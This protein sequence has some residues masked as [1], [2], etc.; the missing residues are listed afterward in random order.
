V[1]T[2]IK[3]ITVKHTGR[4]ETGA[5]IFH[6]PTFDPS[7]NSTR[8]HVSPFSP[9]DVF[10]QKWIHPNNKLA[11]WKSWTNCSSTSS[12]VPLCSGQPIFL[13]VLLCMFHPMC[14]TFILWYNLTPVH[15]FHSFFYSSSYF[16]GS[17]MALFRSVISRGRSDHQPF[18]YVLYCVLEL[19]F[20]THLRINTMDRTQGN[21]SSL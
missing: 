6:P 21:M 1:W 18:I 17:Y 8:P 15:L 7:H 9:S 4:T 3:K 5:L 12:Y 2:H 10:T 20:S 13:H 16:V 19:V 14:C 11:Y